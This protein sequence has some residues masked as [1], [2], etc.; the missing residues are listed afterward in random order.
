MDFRIMGALRVGDGARDHTPTAAKHRDLL[1]LFVLNPRRPMPLARLHHLLWPHEDDERSDSL[2]RGYVGRLR[3]LIGK[4]VITTVAGTYTLVID[5]DQIDVH[6]FRRLVEEGLAAARDGR[7]EHARSL[8]GEALELWRGPVLEDVDPDGHRW[9]ETSAMREELE[10]LRLLAVERRVDLDLKAG[11]HRELVADLRRLVR[12]HPLWQRFHG[13]HMLALYRSGR[14]VEALE[15]Y[16]GLRRAMD[17]GHA[18][19]PDPELQLLYHRMLHDDASLHITAGP[20]VL[21]PNDVTHFTG[22]Q[23][24]LAR[25]E[26]LMTDPEGPAHVVVHGQ[27]GAGKSAL[28]VHAAWR[29]RERFPDGVFYADLRGDQGLPVSAAAVLEDLLRWLGCP[30]QAMPA[31]LQ[32]RERLFRAYTAGRRMLLLLDNAWQESQVRPLLISCPTIVTGRSPLGGL[33]D[34]VRLPV[35]VLDDDEATALLVRLVGPHRA[36]AEPEATRRLGRACGGLPVALRIAGSRLAAR[37]AWT[38]EHLAALLDDEH[39][40]LDLLHSGDQTVRSVYSIGYDELPDGARHVLC[41]LGALS[42][43]DFAQWVATLFGGEAETLVDAGLLET[44]S[45]DAAGQVRYRMHDMTRLYARERLVARSGEDAVR[46]TLTTLASVVMTRVRASRFPLVSGVRADRPAFATTDIRES[47]NWL[48]A[49]R[50]FLTSLVEDLHRAG[51]WDAAWRLAHLLTP[52]MERHRFL[53]SW[54]HVGELALEAARRTGDGRAE[55]LALRDLGDL[56]RAEPRWD[57]AHERLRLALGMFMRAGSARDVAHTR[58]RLGQV[59]LEQGRPADAERNLTACLARF[60]ERADPSGA[61]DARRAL[62][63]VLH[64]T[65][66]TDEAADE[67]EKAVSILSSLGDRHRHADALLDLAS[68]R[69]SQLLVPEARVLVQ[70]ARG[71]SV[72]LGDRL[73]NARAL[74]VLAEADLTEGATGAAERAS[75]LSREALAVFEGAGDGPGRE[76]A[77]DV[78][79]RSGHP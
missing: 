68:V 1:A 43:P 64:R 70:E 8:L 36:A 9:A 48:L 4:D 71:I 10:E 60:D 24:S 15:A 45:I 34:V 17:D 14:R 33:T 49:E 47:V 12:L 26:R 55:A 19:E 40:R 61:A 23:S 21:L 35:D 27:A 16:T 18:I 69:L 37:P 7:D 56:Y 11:R 39:R 29:V 42:A 79:A 22:R 78:L 72:R 32:Q 41:A 53:D 75:R 30:V 46:Q 25:L 67:L 20:P 38:V 57:D 76:K 31:T 13:Q 52:F 28:A 5:D 54:R 2:V 3:Q 58:R 44:H 73:L 65:G 59:L 63:T 50:V 74:L 6:R 66:R 51:L 62:G 77:L